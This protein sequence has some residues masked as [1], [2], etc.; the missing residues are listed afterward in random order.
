[1]TC[2]RMSHIIEYFEFKSHMSGIGDMGKGRR[3]GG[4]SRDTE[5]IM[6]CQIGEMICWNWGKEQGLI[7]HNGGRRQKWQCD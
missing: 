6:Q 4:Q 2:C 3:A 5:E 1:M 7:I